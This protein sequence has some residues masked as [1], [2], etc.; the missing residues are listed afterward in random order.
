LRAGK[1]GT[2]LTAVLA[3]V[4]FGHSSGAVANFSVAMSQGA[5]E[6][7]TTNFKASLTIL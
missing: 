6:A 7:L 3:A 4:A 1:S 2:G 5:N